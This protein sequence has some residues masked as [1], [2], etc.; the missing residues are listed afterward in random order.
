MDS[1]GSLT[2]A[3]VWVNVSVN[4]MIILLVACFVLQAL[5]GVI[6][7][8][9]HHRVIILAAITAPKP[10]AKK[11]YTYYHEAACALLEI[12]DGEEVMNIQEE[13]DFA[14][15]HGLMSETGS[16][17][18]GQSRHES[19]DMQEQK[20]VRRNTGDSRQIHERTT[21]LLSK[22]NRIGSHMAVSRS[23]RLYLKHS[24]HS[25]S[26]RRSEIETR[27]QQS[28]DDGYNFSSDLH[29]IDIQVKLPKSPSSPAASN[30]PY[31]ERKMLTKE[32]LITHVQG[33]PWPSSISIAIPDIDPQS[34]NLHSE[35]S[36]SSPTEYHG[37][38]ESSSP[39]DHTFSDHAG[40]QIKPEEEIYTPSPMKNTGEMFGLPG[41]SLTLDK[42]KIIAIEQTTYPEKYTLS[43]PQPLKR[44]AE[45][46]RWVSTNSMS[47]M[48][49]KFAYFSEEGGNKVNMQPAA[50]EVLPSLVSRSH[51]LISKGSESKS[52]TGSTEKEYEIESLGRNSEFS[53]GMSQPTVCAEIA[54]P[55]KTDSGRI[56]AENQG[57]DEIIRPTIFKVQIDKAF[58]IND[59]PADDAGMM[60]KRNIQD[61]GIKSEEVLLDFRNNIKPE[62]SELRGE[63]KPASQRR[64]SALIPRSMSN[65]QA[66]AAAAVSAAAADSEALRQIQLRAAARV[67]SSLRQILLAQ[68]P[69]YSQKRAHL[70]SLLLML[71][72][73]VLGIVYPTRNLDALVNSPHL[74]DQANRRRFLH[75]ACVHFAREL[76]LADGLSRLNT[77]ELA[78]G[79]RWALNSLKA[80]DKAARLGGTLGVRAGADVGINCE[81]HNRWMYKVIFPNL[82]IC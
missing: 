15:R 44:F 56:Q 49:T 31:A 64:R 70:S 19:Q 33:S 50:Q 41:S 68:L 72:L 40:H 4:I 48:A 36:I 25:A 21:S 3:L 79:L 77:S 7:N 62:T 42:N 30:P 35:S 75:M 8:V 14:S 55:L 54:E 24:V 45:S 17:A 51:S 37:L 46:L 18:L 61:T 12:E 57:G 23:F 65:A 43:S 76:V 67:S 71:L 81:V 82:E 26:L 53:Q 38:S 52:Q 39:R 74:A 34:K 9:Q 1:F 16:S 58:Q 11:L 5:E 47:K 6:R 80:A 63:P 10:V 27:A 29:H 32:N 20:P 69:W 66:E 59:A 2:H 73:C 78:A 28:S 13:N 22:E 60:V